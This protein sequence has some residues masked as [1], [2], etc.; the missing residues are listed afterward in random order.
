MILPSDYILV[1]GV[2]DNHRRSKTQELQ[3]NAV[4]SS[5]QNMFYSCNYKNKSKA[6]VTYNK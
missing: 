6:C 5:V 1:Q 3:E 2:Q 4:L